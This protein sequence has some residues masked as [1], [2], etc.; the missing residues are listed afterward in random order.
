MGK[1]VGAYL[2]HVLRQLGYQATLRVVAFGHMFPIAGDSRR[3]AQMGT[4]GWGSEIPSSADF[5]LPELT[6]QSFYQ[7]PTS[8]A[9]WAE[10]CDPH[11]DQLVSQAR[12][13]QQA[14]PAAA[15]K[16]WAQ[17]DRVVTDQAPWVPL[18]NQSWAW[19]VSARVHNCQESPEYAG[20]LLDQ[21]WVR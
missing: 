6:C 17:A 18:F 12:A 11:A 4:A 5:F 15:R 16:L 20:P 9:N 10:F 19:F 3:K 8:T 1:P 14:D 21:M 13:A 7:D 2:V